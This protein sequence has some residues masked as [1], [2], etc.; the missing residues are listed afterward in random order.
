M[1]YSKVLWSSFR[2][3]DRIF[4]VERVQLTIPANM[5][6]GDWHQINS[7]VYGSVFAESSNT[8]EAYR[9]TVMYKPTGSD[10]WLPASSITG[11]AQLSS[12]GTS[13]G[14]VSGFS[15]VANIMMF[16]GS[17]VNYERSADVVIMLSPVKPASVTIYGIPMKFGTY[18]RE[19]FSNTNNGKIKWSSFDKQATI[20]D[21]RQIVYDSNATARRIATIPHNITGKRPLVKTSCYSIAGMPGRFFAA[22]TSD[23]VYTWRDNTN[24]YVEYEP[25]VAQFN[26]ERVVEVWWYYE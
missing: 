7:P 19:I 8:L 14:F 2:Q 18:G 4:H 1:D 23:Y 20:A 15:A 10:V 12:S 13:V 6:Q 26:G 21:S 25:P 3:T 22:P 9:A 11:S 24:I 16:A 5:T 17:A